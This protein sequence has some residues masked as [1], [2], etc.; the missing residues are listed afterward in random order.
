[1]YTRLS[2]WNVCVA[3]TPYFLP[4]PQGQPL[5]ELE[6]THMFLYFLFLTQT[7]REVDP[8]HCRACISSSWNMLVTR[9]CP[10]AE[11]ALALRFPLTLLRCN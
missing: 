11:K 2:T 5:E 10:T 4:P 1:M 3:P 9:A 8:P 7:Q 6:D